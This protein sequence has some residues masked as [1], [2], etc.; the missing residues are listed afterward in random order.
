MDR[1][2]AML[3]SRFQAGSEPF[4]THHLL[5]SHDRFGTAPEVGEWVGGCAAGILMGTCKKVPKG[6]MVVSR[7]DPSEGDCVTNLRLRADW[8]LLQGRGM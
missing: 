3:R 2:A 5:R 1:T 7:G 8:R 4:G 6:V